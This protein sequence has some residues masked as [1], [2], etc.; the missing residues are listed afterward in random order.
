[1]EVCTE[2]ANLS[3]KAKLTKNVVFNKDQLNDF[4]EKVINMPSIPLELKEYFANH[5]INDLTNIKVKINRKTSSEVIF[6]DSGLIINNAGEEIFK[7][8]IFPNNPDTF[9]ISSLHRQTQKTNYNL[10]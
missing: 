2:T 9:Y 8:K 10:P 4:T 3:V 5:F 6:Y 7:V 1:M